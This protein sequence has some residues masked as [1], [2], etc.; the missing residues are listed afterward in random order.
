MMCHTSRPGKRCKSD[1]Q[2]ILL[3]IRRLSGEEARG[4]VRNLGY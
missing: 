4:V 2:H 1:N 3:A